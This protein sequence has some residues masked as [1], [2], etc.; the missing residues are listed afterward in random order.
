MA[1]SSPAAA[2]PPKPVRLTMGKSFSVADAVR[3]TEEYERWLI[4][5]DK[6]DFGPFSLAQVMARWT[7]GIFTGDD[8]IVDVDSGD[9]QRIREHPQLIEFTRLNERRLEAQRR[10]QAERAHEHVERKEGP[11]DSAHHRYGGL[12][13]GRGPAWFIHKRVAAKD[14][15]LASRVSEADVD[16]FLKEVKISFP[17]HKRG[18]HRSG[19]GGV[20]GRAEDFNNNMDLGDV[21]QGGATPSW[22]RARSTE[23]CTPTTADSFLHHGQGRSD[24]RGRLRG[25]AHGT[26]QGG[27]GQWSGQRA[28]AHVHL[29]SDAVLRLSCLQRQEHHRQLVD[30]DPLTADGRDHTAS[31]DS[32][33]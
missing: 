17:E 27:A 10:A 2:A 7:R 23:S 31:A 15:V 12:G 5:K 25:P 26:G 11:L 3:L 14:D 6:L 4:Q 28:A 16:A 19:P 1:G 8:I 32:S 21:S 18:V 20:A 29:E 24:H 30:V 9:R 22:T 13:T 33:R